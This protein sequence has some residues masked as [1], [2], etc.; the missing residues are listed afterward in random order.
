M[1]RKRIFL[2]LLGLMLSIG[3]AYGMYQ[4]I[5]NLEKKINVAVAIKQI[6]AKEKLGPENVAMI[7]LPARYVLPNAISNIN[8]LLDKET[9]T[10]I[11]QGEQII[12]DRISETEIKPS[13]NERLF[14]IPAENIVMKSGESVDIYL[15]Y[16]AGKSLYEGAERL[17][18][19]KVIASVI[20]QSGI[21]V[22]LTHEEILLYLDRKRFSEEVIVRHGGED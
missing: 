12:Q 18:T 5:G 10:R 15:V 4:N 17:L 9:K 19:D 22:L 14:F 7:S 13:D 2:I 16:T 6:N 1:H 11:Y 8:I 20:K 21:E 3:S